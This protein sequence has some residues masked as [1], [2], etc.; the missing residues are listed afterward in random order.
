MAFP[1]CFFSLGIMF[2]GS[3]HVVAWTRTSCLFVAE[4][5]PLY[6]YPMMYL[7]IH[8]WTDFPQKTL[9]LNISTLSSVPSEEL[10]WELIPLCHKKG[11]QVH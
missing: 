8:P 10:A 1:V 4:K 5:I 9:L 7:S 3:V 6:E 2:L 11:P